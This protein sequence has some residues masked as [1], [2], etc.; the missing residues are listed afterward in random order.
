MASEP[1]T[2]TETATATKLKLDPP[3]ALQPIATAEASGLVPLKS[4]EVSE[5]DRKVAQLVD[6][7]AALDSNSPEFGKKVDALTAMGR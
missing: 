2:A 7:L 6:E 1:G 3:E 4:D 5:L